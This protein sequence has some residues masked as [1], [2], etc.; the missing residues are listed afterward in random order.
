VYSELPGSV[1]NLP[2]RHGGTHLENPCQ[3][4][5]LSVGRKKRDARD[6]FPVYGSCKLNSQICGVVTKHQLPSLDPS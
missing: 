4:G 3:L 5:N 6:S 2:M 1:T